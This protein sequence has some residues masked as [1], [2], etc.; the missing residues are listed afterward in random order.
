MRDSQIP[1]AV[2]GPRAVAAPVQVEQG[3]FPA[4][5]VRR[6]PFRRPPAQLGGLDR[7]P[8]RRRRPDRGGVHGRPLVFDGTGEQPGVGQKLL[9]DLDPRMAHGS[10]PYCA[11]TSDERPVPDGRATAD[12]FRLRLVA[13]KASSSAPG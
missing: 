4:D 6:Q 10:G 1:V 13:W 11:G 2:E 9:H 5:P 7:H 12:G 3:G 8:F